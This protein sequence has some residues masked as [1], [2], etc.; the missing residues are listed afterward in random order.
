MRHLFFKVDPEQAHCSFWL[1]SIFKLITIDNVHTVS[2]SLQR[3]SYALSYLF[4]KGLAAQEAG[5]I[6]LLHM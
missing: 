4:L 5:M 3:L 1:L 6:T 2:Y